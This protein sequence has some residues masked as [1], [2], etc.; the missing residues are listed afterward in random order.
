MKTMQRSVGTNGSSEV[1]Q[2]MRPL[3]PAPLFLTRSPSRTCW[4]RGRMPLRCYSVHQDVNVAVGRIVYT[5]WLNR[6]GGME[7]D[8]TIARTADE[9]FFG[10]TAA[11][12]CTRDLAWVRLVAGRPA[13][14]ASSQVIELIHLPALRVLPVPPDPR[15]R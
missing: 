3:A 7:S 14:N 11:V 13:T 5:P 12:Q 8:A 15:R 4:Y 6:R 9:E 1:A 2:S 10:V